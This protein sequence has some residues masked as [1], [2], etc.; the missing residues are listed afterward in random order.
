MPHV[1][2]NGANLHYTDVGNGPETIFFVHGLAFDGRMFEAQIDHF[3]SRYRCIAMDLRGHGQSDLTDSGYDMD[4]MADDA[5]ALMKHLDCGPCHFVGWSIGG[6]MGMRVAIAHP[7]LLK[8]LTLIGTASMN[9][10]DTDVGFKAVPW[11]TRMF[12]MG[13]VT[14]S[15]MSAMFGKPFLKDPARTELREEWRRRF[16]ADHAMGVSRA[17]TGVIQMASLDSELGL[18]TTP[19][20]MMRGEFDAVVPLGPTQRTVEK[21]RGAKLV[22]IEGAGHGCT[23][24]EPEKVKRAMETFLAGVPA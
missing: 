19:T 23:I 20:I 14:G 2:I 6:F 18:I 1:Q 17:A 5:A 15:L 13:A 10:S 3:K 21:I 22:A 24:E 8:S 16:R 4:G 11:L 9:G 12:G 7:E